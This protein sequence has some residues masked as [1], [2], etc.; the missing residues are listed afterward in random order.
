MEFKV[1]SGIS[2]GVE[3]RNSYAGSCLSEV[4][5]VTFLRLEPKKEEENLDAFFIFILSK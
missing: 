1:T 5:D 2:D 4:E 3:S